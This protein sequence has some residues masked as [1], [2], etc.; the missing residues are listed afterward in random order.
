MF[1]FFERESEIEKVFLST[2]LYGSMN[3]M[4]AG[5]HISI[6]IE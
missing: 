5:Y 4:P 6:F 1:S 2:N 3:Q